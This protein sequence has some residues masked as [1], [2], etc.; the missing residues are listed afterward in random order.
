M[1]SSG[2]DGRTRVGPASTASLVPWTDA[3]DPNVAA[4]CARRCSPRSRSSGPGRGHAAG[5]PSGSRRRPAIADRASVADRAGAASSTV[6]HDGARPAAS[7]RGPRATRTAPRPRRTDRHVRTPTADGLDADLMGHERGARAP[8]IPTGA[9]GP[10]RV[11][12]AVNVRG[13][14][15]TTAPAP[16]C[17]APLRLPVD[18]LTSLAGRKETDPKVFY[19]AYDDMFVLTFLVYD[20][21]ARATSRWSR[22]HRRRPRTRARGASHTHGRRSGR[23]TARTS[24]PTTRASDSASNR[25]VAHD[26][27]LR[28]QRRAVPLRAESSRCRSPQLYDDP[29]CTKTVPIEVARVAPRPGTPTVRRPSPCKRRRPRA[30]RRRISTWSRSSRSRRRRSSSCGVCTIAHGAMSIAKVAEGRQT[31]L[32]AAL[33]VPVQRHDARQHLVGHGRP[34]A[35]VRVLRRRHASA[36]RGHRG[37][38][39][40]RRRSERVGDPLVR[41]DPEAHVPSVTW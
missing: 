25:V 7:G 19:D 28:L 20:S 11:V 9:T 10:T 33:R 17:L 41:G 34:A 4:I 36:V 27:Q 3:P 38:G 29:T 14:P 15:S 35:H 2:R 16:S 32:A 5:P 13:R 23:T 30:P 39:Q 37:Q 40:R 31:G 6:R 22:S 1:P 18:Q 21:S 26:E 8:A 12:A 24:S